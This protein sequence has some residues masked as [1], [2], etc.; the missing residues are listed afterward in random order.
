[1][2]ESGFGVKGLFCKLVVSLGLGVNVDTFKINRQ[3]RVGN[4]KDVFARLYRRRLLIRLENGNLVD[5][6]EPLQRGCNPDQGFG[7]AVHLHSGMTADEA[8]V[9][10][11]AVLGIRAE[12]IEIIRLSSPIEKEDSNRM[13]RQGFGG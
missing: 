3:S 2:Q 9:L 13:P 8:L 5:D 12:M 1:M 11:R 4:T 6:A 7:V 10:I